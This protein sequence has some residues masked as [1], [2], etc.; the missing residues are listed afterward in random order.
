[1]TLNGQDFHFEK[2]AGKWAFFSVLAIS[3][4]NGQKAANF[5]EKGLKNSEL[6]EQISFFDQSI[7]GFFA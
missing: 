6:S 7:H 5:F 4:K 3:Q 1:M 2:F